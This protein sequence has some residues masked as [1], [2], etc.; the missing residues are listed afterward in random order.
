MYEEITF[1]NRYTDFFPFLRKR[2]N[3]SSK[4]LVQQYWLQNRYTVSAGLGCQLFQ[5]CIQTKKR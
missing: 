5:L 2:K 4:I 3:Q 1:L